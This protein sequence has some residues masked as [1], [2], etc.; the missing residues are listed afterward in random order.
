VE[1]IGKLHYR[2][3][4][5]ADGFGR[6]HDAMYVAEGIGE[7]VS[8]LRERAPHRRG[9]GGVVKAGPGDSAY[10]AYDRRITRQAQDWL[11]AHATDSRPWVLFVS[12]VN[13]HPPLIAPPDLY[14]R[15]NPAVLPLPQQWRADDWPDHPALH[16][17]RRY[18]G[19]E[20]PLDEADLRRQLATYYAQCEFIDRQ[21]GTVLAA[22]DAH[23]LSDRTRILYTSDHG[24]M[25]GAR[26]LYGKFTL[27][28]E[29]AAIPLI[30]AG[31]DIPADHVVQTPVSLLDAAP[32]ILDAVGAPPSP[33][34]LPGSS[35]FELADRPD[36]ARYVFSEYHAAGS[37]H[38]AFMLTDGHYKYIHYVNAHAQLFDLRADPAELRDLAD[39]PA[40]Q[41]IRAALD[42]ELR[43]R[44]DPD[45]T[46]RRA[47]ADQRAKVEEFGGEAAVLARGLS[48]SPIPGEA[49]VFQRNLTAHTS[50]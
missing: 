6:K 32:T 16:E 41:P 27:Y 28:D 43:R 21:V 2:R 11:A 5:D 25:L 13:P 15:Y 38:A 39:D 35:L 34:P 23:S 22:L 24:A 9:R 14:A 30:I 37:L 8:C 1:S 19:W 45:A 20:T 50:G 7:V 46:D 36:H 42:S 4:E 40:H 29:A 18:F 3:A 31:P 33:T 44:L 12:Y 17:F 10:L 47:R 26:G 49:P 48:N